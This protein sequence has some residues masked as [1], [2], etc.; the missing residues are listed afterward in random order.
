[1]IHSRDEVL[2]E[3]RP[4]DGLL[5]GMWSFPEVEVAGPRDAAAAATRLATER[6][7]RVRVGARPLLA[8]EHRFTHLHV[9]YLPYALEVGTPRARGTGRWVRTSRPVRL[10][11]PVA[12]RRVLEQFGVTLRGARA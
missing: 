8:L 10:A 6:G 3:R 5:G 7:L 2:L 12:Q 4:K 1:V 11:L 9:C